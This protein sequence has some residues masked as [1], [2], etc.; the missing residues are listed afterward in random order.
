[1]SGLTKHELFYIE[2]YLR[3]HQAQDDFL[4]FCQ[5]H[6]VES[7]FAEACNQAQR[8][9]A[10]HADGLAQ[11]LSTTAGPAGEALWKKS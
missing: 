6:I 4:Q 10:T 3:F 8:T 2:E 1:M 9:L 11:Y 5:S 7:G